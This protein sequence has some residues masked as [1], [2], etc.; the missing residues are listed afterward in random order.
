MIHGTDL[1]ENF[2]IDDEFFQEPED[3]L[4][5]YNIETEEELAEDLPEDIEYRTSQLEPVF[6]LD[7]DWILGRIDEDRLDENGDVLDKIEKLLKTIDFNSVNEKMPKM[8][9]EVGGKR[10]FKRDLLKACL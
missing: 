9:Y 8:W 7:A 2:F 5:Q 1:P 6:K 10:T 3:L 4:E